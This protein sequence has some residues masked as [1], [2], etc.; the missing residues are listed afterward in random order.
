MFVLIKTALQCCLIGLFLYPFL[1]VIA[2][3]EFFVTKAEASGGTETPNVVNSVRVWPSPSNTRVVFDLKDVPEYTWFTLE[4]PYRLVI[5][6]AK[7]RGTLDFSQIV[8]HSKLVVK[9]RR[10]KPKD[11]RSTRIVL[12]LSKK[13]EPQIFAL[14]PTAPYGN[15][16]VIDLADSISHQ[17]E[18][19][20]QPVYERSQ[21]IIIAIDAGH[22]GRIQ[23]QSDPW[24]HM[25]KML[26]CV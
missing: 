20:K 18:L 22:G 10:S 3:S 23:V 8:N 5:D 25:K 19:I 1:G 21:N 11:K 6:L 16:L 14:K 4:K 26:S 24:A 13:I 12:E 15:R 2:L 7:T 9:L 17:K